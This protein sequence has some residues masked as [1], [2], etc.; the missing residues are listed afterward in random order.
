MPGVRNDR[1]M[2]YHRGI[3]KWRRFGDDGTIV[4][5]RL[6]L[7]TDRRLIDRYPYLTPAWQDA[8]TEEAI[9]TGSGRLGGRLRATMEQLF[10]RWN[11]AGAGPAATKP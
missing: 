2:T 7:F 6:L 3:D 10:T 8:R 1:L 9:L 5:P 4:A 11:Q